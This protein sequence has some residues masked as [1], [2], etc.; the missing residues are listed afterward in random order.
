MTLAAPASAET[1]PLA[2]EAGAPS[3]PRR[4]RADAAAAF[5]RHKGV[6]RG[7]LIQVLAGLLWL[8]QAAMLAFAVQKLADGGGV[9]DLVPLAAGVFALGVLRALLDASGARLCYRSARAALTTLRAQATEALARR[10]PLDPD[11]MASGTAASVLAEQA[12]AVIPY[13]HRFGP[14]RLK[15]SILPLAILAVVLPLS[16]VA[17]LVLL[18]T[19]PPIPIFMAL[20]GYRAKAASERHL[21]E[22]G[23]MNGL[24]LDRLRGLTTI[25]GYGAV[26]AVATQ[27]GKAADTLRRRSM[28]VLRIAF[29]SS[30]VLELFAAIGVAMV[31]VYIGFHLLGALE[32]GAWG[33]KL[34]LGQGLFILLLAPSFFEPMRELSAAWHDRAAG[35][36]AIAAIDR[37]AAGRLDLPGALVSP[38]ETGN[39]QPPSIEVENLTFGYGTAHAVLRNLDLSVRPGEHF[40]IMGPS[41][42]GKSTLLALLAGLAPAT[43]LIRIGGVPMG[44]STAA[45]LRGR[46]GW[47]AQNPHF[48]AGSLRANVSLGREGC[49][50]AEVAAA[51]DVAALD[52]FGG[53]ALARQL[54]EGGAGIS[55]GEGL[56]LSIARAAADP[57]VDIILAD[58]P[59]AH[60]DAE[61]GAEVAERLV[62]MAEGKTL[63][64]VTH[65]PAL[66]A[67]MDRT[68]ILHQGVIDEIDIELMPIKAASA[69][70]ARLRP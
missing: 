33:G 3:Q 22:M 21:A 54:G 53:A 68:L 56:R 43:G 66:A 16:W 62:A 34:G 52:G 46:I 40:A 59:T 5:L 19:L 7:G 48:F 38:A 58:E 31:A 15:V 2:R 35:E 60:L 29:L 37:L 64:V 61:T 44:A 67:R 28:A 30:A 47:V 70:K 25:R 18:C 10:S 24:L 41:G 14:A 32:F 65:D 4:R 57:R 55:G 45:E 49:G 11:R 69:R 13:L 42:A 1:A 50:E 26:D 63:L 12:E 36:A 27:V 51:L 23:D 9:A 20:I 17:G 39:A 6:R 8:P